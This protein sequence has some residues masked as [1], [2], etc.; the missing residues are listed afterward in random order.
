MQ[1]DFVK[2]WNVAGL[3][4]KKEGEKNVQ[5]LTN[6][7]LENYNCHFD[8][9]VP[10]VYPNLAVLGGPVDDFPANLYDF[11]LARETTVKNTG[12]CTH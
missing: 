7:A 6:N 4:K 10:N 8:R 12:A 1:D 3:D 2:V 5:F 9:I 11:F